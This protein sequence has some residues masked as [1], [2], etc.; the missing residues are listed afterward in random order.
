MS[1]DFFFF[2]IIALK[3]IALPQLTL[4]RLRMTIRNYRAFEYNSVFS[5]TIHSQARRTVHTR[6]C[7]TDRTLAFTC[8]H[9]VQRWWE[10]ARRFWHWNDIEVNLSSSN[11]LSLYL[12]LIG[13]QSISELLIHEQIF[14]IQLKILPKIGAFLYPR[15]RMQKG[16]FCRARPLGGLRGQ[17]HVAHVNKCLKHRTKALLE[18]TNNE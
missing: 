3:I 5:H 17:Q 11:L 7:W 13:C 8:L 9:G 4:S 14:Q 6:V 10:R 16:K 2:I 1:N 18:P 15:S 12:R